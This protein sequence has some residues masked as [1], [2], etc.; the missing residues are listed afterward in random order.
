MSDVAS[1]SLRNSLEAIV[2]SERVLDWPVD[3]I[4]FAADAGFYW[5]IPKAVAIAAS[6]EHIRGLFRG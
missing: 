1:T 3:L 5:L 6:V 4:A 2:G